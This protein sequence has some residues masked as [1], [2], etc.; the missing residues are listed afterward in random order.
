MTLGSMVKARSWKIAM[1]GMA[2][3]ALG[4]LPA[5]ADT[6]FHNGRAPQPQVVQRGR[7]AGCDARAFQWD[8]FGRRDD[9]GCAMAPMHRD[10]RFDQH[11]GYG[12]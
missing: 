5:F 6:P 7:D 11:Q 2:M 4:A 10:N 1:V 9:R 12:R 3:V 8:R